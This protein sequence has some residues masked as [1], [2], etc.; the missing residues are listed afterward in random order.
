MLPIGL[1]LMPCPDDNAF[2]GHRNLGP[3]VFGRYLELLVA[4]TPAVAWAVGRALHD[5]R[6]GFPLPAWLRVFGSGA[7]A[8]AAA[9]AAVT[10]AV[11]VWD[12]D[13]HPAPQYGVGHQLGGAV[14]LYL[15]VML[16]ALWSLLWLRR[17]E[18]A[19]AEAPRADAASVTAR[20]AGRERVV[21]A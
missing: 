14:V 17:R 16:P 12:I 1:H 6:D 8:F 2:I 3:L 7:A 4:L 20:G 11:V 18:L 21:E 10:A 9:V 19:L 5:A 13:Q 15:G